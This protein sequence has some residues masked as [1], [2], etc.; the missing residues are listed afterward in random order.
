[1]PRGRRQ[2]AWVAAVLLALASAAAAGEPAETGRFVWS[3]DSAEARTL[4]SELQQGIESFQA[5][6]ASTE[7]ARKIVAADPEFAMGHYYLSATLPFTSEDRQFVLD[8]AVKLA[9]NA[10]DGERR[11]ILALAGIRNIQA[12]T[13]PAVA[14]TVAQLE[15]LAVDYPEERLVQVI[16][17]QIYQAS[18]EAEKARQAFRRCEEIGPSSPRAR[19]FLANADLLDGHY[20]KAR[21]TFERVEASLPKGTAPFTIRYG[22]AFSH[23]YEDHP[24]AALASLRTLLEEYREAGLTQGFPEVF[25]WNSIA[26]INLENGRLEQAMKAYEKGF[27]SVP[28]SSLADDQKAVWQGRLLHG[29]S[30]VLAR[31]DRDDEAWA[32]AE[33]IKAMIEE[34]GEPAE[35][36]WPA[37]HYLAGYLKLEAGEHQAAV[38]HLEKADPNDPFQTLLLARAYEGAGRKDDARQAYK[39]VVASEN[40]GLERALAYPEA[41]KKLVS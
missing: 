2:V 4:L 40:N 19:A 21:G 39:R 10:S 22:I 38:D 35:Q 33:E 20:A 9:E 8:E 37:W 7:L 11:F 14:E 6:P 32:V 31:M 5:G 18:N 26:R 34:S 15:K 13:D 23:L 29:R 28:G 27:E 30:R 41:K 1:M 25:I 17:G 3:T 36:Y 24:D 16:L 12:F